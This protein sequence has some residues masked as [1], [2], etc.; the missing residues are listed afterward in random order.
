MT[1]MSPLIMRA[2]LISSSLQPY[3]SNI[4]KDINNFLPGV[5]NDINQ[6]ATTP[7]NPRD[8]LSVPY[9]KNQIGSSIS[10]VE[11]G[12]NQWATVPYNP[13]DIL[14]LPYWENQIGSDI[15]LIEQFIGHPIKT[16]GAIPEEVAQVQNLAN[17]LVQE[18]AAPWYLPDVTLA[19]MAAPLVATGLGTTGFIGGL[20]GLE[21]AGA[22]TGIGAGLNYGVNGVFT[23]Q[24]TGPQ[25]F[26]NLETGALTA[27]ILSP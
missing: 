23:G 27:A 24:W 7:Y 22:L 2:N 13:R 19:I 9:W 16:V 10:G 8:I 18:G 11:N 14:S 1:D 21:S 25:A 5:Q 20:G 17:Q 15:K 12:I 6:W 4:P 3:L 26:Q